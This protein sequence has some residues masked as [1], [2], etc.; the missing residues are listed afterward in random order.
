MTE[1]FKYRVV[2]EV[3]V[4]AFDADDAFDKLQ[5]AIGAGENLGVLIS[6]CEYKPKKR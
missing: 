5:D 3:E 2:L 1:T 6:D 4:E